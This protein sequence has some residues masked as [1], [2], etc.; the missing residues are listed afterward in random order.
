[1]PESKKPRPPPHSPSPPPP[2]DEIADWE[3]LQERLEDL[4]IEWGIVVASLWKNAMKVDH[5][6]TDCRPTKGSTLSIRLDNDIFN[7]FWSDARGPDDQ[8]PT[9]GFGPITTI[10]TD[11]AEPTAPVPSPQRRHPAPPPP[12]EAGSVKERRRPSR[13]R[14]PSSTS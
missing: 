2:S 8:A 14:M 7:N 9:I 4:G 5:G 11:L 3:T 1:M 6:L 13:T 12:R 10:H